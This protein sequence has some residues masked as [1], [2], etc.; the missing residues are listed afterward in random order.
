MIDD[1]F[2][3]ALTRAEL[4]DD[5]GQLTRPAEP[6][7]MAHRCVERGHHRF[8]AVMRSHCA[9][10]GVRNPIWHSP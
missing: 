5:E 9:D 7:P 1:F 4:Y 6:Y 2:A 8:E 10:D 3:D